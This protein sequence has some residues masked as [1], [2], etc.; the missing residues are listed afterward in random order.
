MLLLLHT[1]RTFPIFAGVAATMRG[2]H[3]RL[4]M[5]PL[6]SSV[7]S[8]SGANHSSSRSPMALKFLIAL[9]EARRTA[10]V[11]KLLNCPRLSPADGP[12]ELQ[13]QGASS[14]KTGWCASSQVWQLLLADPRA[15]NWRAGKQR[16]FL[17]A[18]CLQGSGLKSL[19]QPLMARSSRV[20][21]VQRFHHWK[22]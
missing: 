5:Q 11:P 13:S 22:G 6:P 14:C 9:C 7:Q 1:D 10:S 2:R 3:S 20:A 16:E 17:Y 18:P 19:A 4:D 15:S 12:Q 8:Q 21:L